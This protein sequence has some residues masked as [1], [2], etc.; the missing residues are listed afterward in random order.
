MIKETMICDICGNEIEHRTHFLRIKAKS[1]R[2]IN[3]SNFD[4]IGADLKK[5]DICIPCVVDFQTFVQL[6]HGDS[7]I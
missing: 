3:Y 6:R 5:F 7:Q 1:T 2:F 4:S